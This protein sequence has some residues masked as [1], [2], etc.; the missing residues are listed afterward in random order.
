MKAFFKPRNPWNCIRCRRSHHLVHWGW[1]RA[2]SRSLIYIYNRIGINCS[3]HGGYKY[4]VLE[5]ALPPSL[6]Q[7]TC[8]GGGVGAVFGEA[9][10]FFTTTRFWAAASNSAGQGECRGFVLDAFGIHPAILLGS[11]LDLIIVSCDQPASQDS[12]IHAAKRPGFFSA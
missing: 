2:R 12:Y 10:S 8:T 6:V 7:E 3:Q 9:G 11:W 4:N 5:A 1:H